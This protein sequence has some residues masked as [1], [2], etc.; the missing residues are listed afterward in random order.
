[1]SKIKKIYA[2]EIIDSRGYPTIESEVHL[3]DGSIGIAS[4]PSGASTG[5][6]EALELRDKNKEYFFG[7]GVLKS[8]KNVNDIIS[9][10]LKNKN[11]KNQENID[12]IM[13]KEDGTKNK[14]NLGA[15]S[16][17]SVSLAVSKA[18]SV[19]KKINLYEHIYKLSGQTKKIIMPRPMINIING[20]KHS[21]NNLDIQEFMIQ[22]KKNIPIKQSIKMGCEIF[23]SLYKILKSKNISISVGDEGGFA[24]NLKNNEESFKLIKKAI[25]NTKY[26]LGKDLNI[27][28]DCAGSELYNKL[29]DKYELKNEKKIFNYKT[30]TKYLKQLSIKYHIK[31]IED[32]LHEDDWK[33]FKYHTKKIGKKVQIVGDDLFVTNPIILKKGILK[34]SANAILIK[35]NQIGTLTETL[36]T[37]YIA[38][39]AN[40]NTIISHRSGETEDT[41]IADL[42]IGTISDQVKMGSMSRSE[43]TAKYNRLIRIE[44][45]LLKKKYKISL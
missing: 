13:I 39:K 8:V 29:N 19:H 30:F 11:A 33:G 21:N 32:P 25:K 3:Q 27:A 15:N 40:Y 42:S 41:F 34:K 36:E 35:L 44:E 23:H 12:E 31:S 14:S 4:V 37:I 5:S 28:I 24:P 22:P 43:R 20:G 1:M 38:K 2:R 6:K 17:L 26:I 10:I 9:R 18:Y 16:I 7:Y 45:E